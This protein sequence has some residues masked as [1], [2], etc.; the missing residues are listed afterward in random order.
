MVRGS[1]PGGG[2]FSA[3]LQTGPEA[4]PASYTMG[5]ASFPGVKRPGRSTD[6]SPP[7]SAEIKERA[8]LYL[9]SPSGP[10]WPVLGRTL[11]FTFTFF[12]QRR[13][14]SHPYRTGKL[15]TN[16][17]LKKRYYLLLLLDD[18]SLECNSLCC[19]CNVAM[20]LLSSFI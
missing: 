11:T 15:I 3:P 10:L 17:Q 20:C 19:D 8:E 1:N 16:M 14:V 2:K 5:I 6:H 9:N 18:M 12:S 4:H 7:S 13:D